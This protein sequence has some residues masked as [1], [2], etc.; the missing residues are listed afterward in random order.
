MLLRPEPLQ[1]QFLKGEGVS[2]GE[3]GLVITSLQELGRDLGLQCN[4]GRFLINPL[5]QPMYQAPRTCLGLW[6]C[7]SSIG[8]EAIAVPSLGGQ[9]PFFHVLSLLQKC[10]DIFPSFPRFLYPVLHNILF[11]ESHFRELSGG[12]RAASLGPSAMFRPEELAFGNML[13]TQH[14]PS[15]HRVAQDRTRQESDQPSNGCP[16]KAGTDRGR[17]KEPPSGVQ[18]C[19]LYLFEGGSSRGSGFQL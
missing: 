5:A 13:S 6:G 16:G 10:T 17:F 7:F 18:S 8:T 14:L 12:R 15:R 1:H 19:P 11:Y 9:S 2:L 4:L 3:E